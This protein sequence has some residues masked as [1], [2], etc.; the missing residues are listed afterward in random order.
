MDCVNNIDHLFVEY[1]SDH[2]TRDAMMNLFDAACPEDSE[3]PTLARCLSPRLSIYVCTGDGKVEAVVYVDGSSEPHMLFLGNY[4]NSVTRDR[5]R[6]GTY[7]ND[8]RY[9]N[10]LLGSVWSIEPV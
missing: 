3:W 4:A 5:V 10:A 2:H 1:A 7:L 6:W 9:S 8:W